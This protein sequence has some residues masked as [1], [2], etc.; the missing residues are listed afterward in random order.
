M[1]ELS[2]LRKTP[3]PLFINI[4]VLDGCWL[5]VMTEKMHGLDQ[6]KNL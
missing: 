6:Y 1:D 3:L 2:V 5:R 4:F